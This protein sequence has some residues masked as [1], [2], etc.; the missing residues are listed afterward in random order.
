MEQFLRF[1]KEYN[2]AQ[3]NDEVYDGKVEDAAVG[4]LG[5]IET[6]LQVAT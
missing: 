1:S 3:L 2:D 6:L 5:I 4:C